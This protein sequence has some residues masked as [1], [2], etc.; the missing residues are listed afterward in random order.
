M[1]SI[2]LPIALG[3]TA[4]AGVGSAV[5]GAS[6]AKSAAKTQAQAADTASGNTLAMFNQTKADLSPF[7]SAGTG[8]VNELTAQL[9]ELTKTF[10]PTMAQLEQT[11][12]YQFSLDQGLKATQ[13]G[14]AAQGL[15]TSGAALKGGAQYAQG[16]ASTTFQQQFQNYLAQNQQKYN[17]YMGQSQLGE[18][19]AAMTGQQ[20]LTATGQ[21]GNFLTSG[22]AASAAGTVGAANAITGGL[23]NIG[24]IGQ[25]YAMSNNGLFGGT[26]GGTAGGSA[27]V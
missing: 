20:G 8:A 6:A 22:A 16:L 19:A 10:D 14:F 9:P 23:S 21:A 3:V 11:P 12:G 24:S 7:V 15:A 27:G 13:N 1:P 17:M 18:N 26:S 5:I 25:L 4:A 2:S